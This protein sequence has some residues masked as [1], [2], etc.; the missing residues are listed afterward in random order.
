M[1]SFIIKVLK[2]LLVTISLWGLIIY[3][4][5]AAK[6]EYFSGS[7]SLDYSICTYQYDQINKKTAYTNIIIGDSRG[8]ASIDPKQ[9][10][11]KWLNLSIPGSDFFEGYL[12]LNR[13]LLNNKVDTLLMVYG[14]NYMAENSPYFTRRTI[15]FQFLN[16]NEL[17]EL[18]QVERKYNYLFHGDATYGSYALRMG[19]FERKLK[20]LHFPFYYRETFLDGLYSFMRSPVYLKSQK[21]KIIARL[22]NDLGH[23]NFGEADS[24][25][26][27][28]INGESIFNPKP[29][30]QYYLDR[31]MQLASQKRITVFLVPAPMN[32]SSFASY[33]GSK[34][35]ASV[36]E[37]FKSLQTK[38]PNLFLLK[39]PAS[40]PNTMFG[41]PYHVNKKGTVVFT[42]AARS[43]LDWRWP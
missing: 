27:D 19:Q 29:I 34:F 3:A 37:Y 14:I 30:S 12:T 39:T 41:D 28:N 15:P 13:H 38:Y 24:N 21:K 36:N 10:G 4:F 16:N 9:L 8:N 2:Y 22:S 43:K 18:E 23:M 40:L 6:P 11:E 1:N 25:N 7:S 33:S 17:N 20:Y 42:Q 5:L 32:Q 31:L 35:E 26:T